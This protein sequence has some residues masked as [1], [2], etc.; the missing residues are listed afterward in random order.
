MDKRNVIR[1]R[2]VDYRNHTYTRVN[3]LKAS[4]KAEILD[5]K[6]YKFPL[7]ELL[8]KCKDKNSVLDDF[9]CEYLFWDIERKAKGDK[10]NDESD[11]GNGEKGVASEEHEANTLEIADYLMLM[12]M[13]N[14]PSFIA[15]YKKRYIPLMSSAPEMFATLLEVERKKQNKGGMTKLIDAILKKMAKKSA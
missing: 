7:D 1:T 10:K 9:E 6:R 15:E 12:K 2:W 4:R 5:E 3:S 13:L 14:N 11:E 8:E